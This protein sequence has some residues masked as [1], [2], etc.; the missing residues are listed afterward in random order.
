NGS[1][2]FKD[3]EL[4]FSYQGAYRDYQ[5]SYYSSGS[6]Q[7]LSIGYNKRLSRHLSMS[8]GLSGGIALYG[9]T[10]IEG[11]PAN[12]TAVVTNPFSPETK[13]VSAGI[14]LGYQQTRRLSYTVGGSFFLS[15]YNGP[16]AIGA[17]G[18]SGTAAVNYRLT[19]R[20]SVSGIYSHSYF[21]YQRNAGQSYVDQVG[22]SVNH[23]FSNHW[24]ASLYAG[25]ARSVATGTV[26]VPVT[27]LVGNQAI[28]GYV[29]GRYNQT[30]YVPS[31][32]GSV[33]HSYRR[34]LISLSAGEGIFGSG[35]GYYLASR[36]IYASGIF[37]YSL[38]GQ[39]I[40]FGGG[41]NRLSSV[42]NSL[43]TQ[44]T[45]ATF[46]ASY[47][48][49]LVRYVGMFLRYDYTH[50]GSLAPFNGVYDNRISF[51]FNFSSRSIPMTLF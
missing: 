44:Y 47:G 12:Q 43:S 26:T 28:G 50:Y 30:A 48:R 13:F 34:S 11:Q 24:N 18:G 2:Q 1:H 29:I 33:S 15:R 19:V 46:S 21:T 7:N 8:V 4:G 25:G 5:S 10:F 6:S 3:A 20:T 14:N 42:A 41:V 38:H 40:S 39:N 37:S 35:N 22:I 31:F 9:G 32:S 27:L 45:S 23:A 17:A 16:G 51:G 49:G 36:S